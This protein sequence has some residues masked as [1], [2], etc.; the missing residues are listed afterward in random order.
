MS[1]PDAGRSP[2]ACCA[3]VPP[4]AIVVYEEPAQGKFALRCFPPSRTP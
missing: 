4:R 1:G 3:A 2:A